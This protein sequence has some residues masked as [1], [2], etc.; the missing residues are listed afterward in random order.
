MTVCLEGRCSIQLSY[1]RVSLPTASS[2]RS[3][4]GSIL[5]FWLKFSLVRG[6]DVG[7]IKA[8]TITVVPF[9]TVDPIQESTV[10][11]GRLALAVLPVLLLVVSVLA[12]LHN[13]NIINP[14]SRSRIPPKSNV[15]RRFH[16]GR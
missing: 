4:V 15:G 12:D 7:L 5:G 9:S 1:E 3:I 8:V 2:P 13:A 6:S 11:L 14:F 10:Q 16:S